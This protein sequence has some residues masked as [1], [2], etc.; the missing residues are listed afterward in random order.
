ME[1]FI[2]MRHRA[3]SRSNGGWAVPFFKQPVLLSNLLETFWQPVCL[4]TPG[5]QSISWESTSQRP[6]A[7]GTSRS[8]A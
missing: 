1:Q 3:P 2:Y 5:S 7:L 8:A 6:S 4:C